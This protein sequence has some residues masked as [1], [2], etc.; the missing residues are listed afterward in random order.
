MMNYAIHADGL[1][2]SRGGNEV[3][4]DVSVDVPAGAIYGLL[5]PSGCG[6]ST[7]MRALVGVQRYT[8]TLRVLDHPAG[9]AALRG[10]IGYMSQA[11]SVYA[12]LTV[13]ENLRY[14]AAMVGAGHAQVA[15]VLDRVG[16]GA[17]A[18]RLV[19]QLSGGQRARVSLAGALLG[20]PPL[21]VL[22]EPT[23]GLDP[24]L[25]QELWSMFSELATAG[26]TLLISSHVMDEAQ[27][28]TQ[29]MLL[30]E[31]R[32][33]VAGRSPAELLADTGARDVEGAFLALVEPG[34]VSA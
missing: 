6:K 23:V 1:S 17:Q 27:R 15:A 25:R 9:A 33:L 16:L 11:P 21:L 2:I 20:E 14:F 19:G 13:A 5:G 7:L 28:C 8:G 34:A 10:Q 4:R 32:V 30:R 31:G 24:V 26:A 18:T 29:L 22:D 3:L 12:D